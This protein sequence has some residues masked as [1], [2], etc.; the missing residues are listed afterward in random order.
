MT[1]ASRRIASAVVITLALAATA[2]AQGVRRGEIAGVVK[3]D[4]GATLPGVTITVT[5]PALQVPSIVRVSDQKGE[6][7]VVDLPAGTYNVR[8]ELAGFGALM[9]EGIVLTTGFAAKV[10]VVLKVASV[11][12]TVTVSGESPVVDVT[13]TRGGATVSK[14]LI[15]QVPGNNNFEDVLLMVGGGQAPN[16]PLTG[17]ASGTAMGFDGSKSYGA[18]AGVA[19]V[20]GMRAMSFEP[21]NFSA[22]EEVDVKT[23]GNTADVDSSGTAV[24]LVLKS[25]G[26]QF[27]GRYNEIFQSDKFQSNNIDDALRAQGITK[28]DSVS[29]FNDLTADLGG[30]IIRDKLWFYINGRDARN[31][32]TSTG[33]VTGPGPDG[34]YQTL[35]DPIAYPSDWYRGG[36]YKISYQMTSKNK[37]ISMWNEN[38]NHYY[39]YYSRYAPLESTM[40]QN[41]LGREIK[42]IEWQSTPSNKLIV[43]VMYAYSRFGSYR[44]WNGGW[45]PNSGAPSRMD[46]NTLQQTGPAFNNN[47]PGASRLPRSQYTGSVS[48]LPSGSYLGSHSI[49]GGFRVWRARYDSVF[50]GGGPNDNCS[51]GT[52]VCPRNV[53]IGGYQLIYDVVNGLPHQAVELDVKNFP[54]M[55]SSH[56]DNDALY[57]MDGWRPTTRLTLNLGLRWERNYYW[58]PAT[59]HTASIPVGFVEPIGVSFSRPAFDVNKWY[60]VV[61]RLGAAYDLSGNGKT[62]VKGTWGRFMTDLQ[63]NSYASSTSPASVATYA[64]TWHDLN[65]D[66]NY[67]PGEVNLSTS[68]P[69]FL[70]VSGGTSRIVNPNLQLTYTDEASAS[71]ER[72]LGSTVSLRGLFVYKRVV[73]AFQSINVLRPLSVWNQTFSRQ[74]PGPDGVLGTGDDGAMLTIYDYN[75]AYR[76]AAFVQNQNVDADANR[77]DKYKNLEVMLTKR[78]SGRWFANTS[79]LA[80]NNH[81]WRVKAVSTGNDNLFP[82]GDYWDLSYLMAGGY[83]LP[84]E[85]LVSALV[86]AYNGLA[87]QRV[88]NFRA[89]DP[90]GGPRFPSSSNLQLPVEAM[91]GTRGPD[92]T[93]V[94]LRTAKDFRM[95]ARTFTASVD[96]FNAFNTNV[97]WGST[98]SQL[99]FGQIGLVDV[100]GP[101]YNQALTIVQPRQIRF[102]VGFEF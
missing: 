78:A 65:N 100:S 39:A 24:Q 37:F 68:G 4:T 21:A 88:V 66:G 28:G 59:Q 89:A 23:F 47:V 73:N 75:P 27:H 11:A 9:R 90:A 96:A 18:G 51:P 97:A 29:R 93:I 5:G 80:T 22:Y 94:N 67:Q 2:L 54:I 36:A 31:K 10:D 57:I 81:V 34:V 32:Y 50:P 45:Q 64:Y 98:N 26:N 79:F 35:D 41:Q 16:T 63:P 82:V 15:A 7:Q 95:G 58:V 101:S 92:R 13:S 48:Y 44:Y 12:E 55:G 84:H 70:G 53:G 62:V 77:H 43:D 76:G 3:D 25:G 72:S 61:P 60:N 49:Q 56:E 1:G 17:G 33:F 87:R 38:N 69:D 102:N 30:R 83:W 14:E 52:M 20:E 99:G 46:R 6:Y 74:D 19:L 40:I 86:Q 42:P 8:Y 71:I 85:I 91:G